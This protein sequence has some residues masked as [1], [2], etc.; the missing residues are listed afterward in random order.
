MSA[1][2]VGEAARQLG[3]AADTLRYYDRI[4]LVRPAARGAA[5]RRLYTAED[6]ARLRFVQRAQAMNYRLAE[7]KALLHLRAQP[8]A[9]RA[10][11]RRLVAEKLSQIKDRLATLTLLRNELELLLN[12]CD[13]GT[14]RCPILDAMDGRSPRRR[15]GTPTS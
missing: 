12:L 1:V 15:A 14:E 6:L 7:I 13:G 5:G 10:E 11:A 3:L 9:P 8:R 4:G 2:T